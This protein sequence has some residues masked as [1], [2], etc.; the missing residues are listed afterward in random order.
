M[1]GSPL[2]WLTGAL[3]PAVYSKHFRREAKI[4]RSLDGTLGGPYIRFARQVLAEAEIGCSDETIAS[5]LR[6]LKE[7]EIDG[8]TLLALSP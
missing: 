2:Q 8:A 7:I 1:S 4:S 5:A 3:L 6:M